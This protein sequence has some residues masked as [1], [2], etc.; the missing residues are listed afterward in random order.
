MRP[1]LSH[2]SAEHRSNQAAPA[3]TDVTYVIP[4]LPRFHLQVVMQLT[5]QQY[6][7]FLMQKSKRRLMLG[8]NLRVFL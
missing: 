4:E 5:V 7:E 8:T 1:W 6:W 2:P 3:M